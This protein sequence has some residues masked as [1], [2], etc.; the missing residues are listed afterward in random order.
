MIVFFC[1][2]APVTKNAAIAAANRIGENNFII[3]WIRP[4]K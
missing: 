1:A 2:I 4:F 3:C